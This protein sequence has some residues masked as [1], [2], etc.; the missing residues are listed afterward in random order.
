MRF[1]LAVIFL[2]GCTGVA[3]FPTRYVTACGM[4]YKGTSPYGDAMEPLGKAEVDHAVAVGLDA[5]SRVSAIPLSFDAMCAR[6]EGYELLTT[7]TTFKLTQPHGYSGWVAGATNCSWSAMEISVNADLPLLTTLTH[8]MAHAVQD[9][10]SP[11][12]VDEGV[13]SWHSDWKRDHIFDAIEFAGKD[14]P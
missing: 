6:L 7:P 9:C 4:L 8:E 2:S 3:D 10:R 12:P 14:S 5:L 1:L 13:D 11:L